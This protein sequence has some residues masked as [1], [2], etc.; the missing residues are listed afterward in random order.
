MRVLVHTAWA[1]VLLFGLEG[2]TRASECGTA[3]LQSRFFVYICLRDY[4]GLVPIRFSLA[5]GRLVLPARLPCSKT[6]Y[7]KDFRKGMKY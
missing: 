3:R 5:L 7:A 2:N 4:L 6:K 1:S